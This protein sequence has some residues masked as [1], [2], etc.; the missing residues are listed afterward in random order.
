MTKTILV[1]FDGKTF[2]PVE[3][4]DLPAGTKAIVRVA[5]NQEHPYVGKPPPPMTDEQRRLWD[6]L[7]KEWAAHP[8]PWETVEEALGRPRYEP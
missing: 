3:P 6:E 1:E 5:V 8:L 7:V 4:V 2:V